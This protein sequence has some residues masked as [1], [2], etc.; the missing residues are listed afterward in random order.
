MIRKATPEDA[1]A[2]VDL[3]LNWDGITYI[4][5]DAVRRHFLKHWRMALVAEKDGKLIGSIGL[6]KDCFWWCDVEYLGDVWYFVHPQYRASRVGLNLLNAAKRSAEKAMLPLIMG[7]V[8]GGDIQRKDKFFERNGFTRL[9][10]TY[11]RGL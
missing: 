2:F 10:G 5:P 8:H 11:A 4:R 6:A 3:I 7:V 9:G 1:D